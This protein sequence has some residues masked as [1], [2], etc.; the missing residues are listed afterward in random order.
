[1]KEMGKHKKDWY[2]REGKPFD[3]KETTINFHQFREDRDKYIAKLNKIYAQNL[4]G[5]KVQHVQGAASFLDNNTL[6]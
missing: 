1:M 3:F 5:S 4:E 2:L 6:E